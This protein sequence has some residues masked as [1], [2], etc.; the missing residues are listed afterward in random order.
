MSTDTQPFFKKHIWLKVERDVPR[1]I[2]VVALTGRETWL[3]VSLPDDVKEPEVHNHFMNHYRTLN[4]MDIPG[5]IPCYGNC[6]GYYFHFAPGKTVEFDLS[7]REVARH[8]DFPPHYL[9]KADLT[10]ASGRPL[11]YRIE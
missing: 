2:F 6:L 3:H 8:E 4:C 1:P 10:D 11:P 7:G 5:R 9:A